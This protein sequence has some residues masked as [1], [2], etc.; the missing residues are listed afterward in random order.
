MLLLLLLLLFLFLLHLWRMPEIVAPRVSY[1]PTA[2]QGK[3]EMYSKAES[4]LSPHSQNSGTTAWI[5]AARRLVNITSENVISASVPH[6][7]REALEP[8]GS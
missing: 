6:E 7:K 2:G 3:R 8:T 4:G 1:F 5:H